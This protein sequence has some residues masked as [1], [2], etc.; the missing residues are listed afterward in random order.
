MSGDVIT[1]REAMRNA[2]TL[3]E[4]LGYT[5]GDIHD[6][7]AQAVARLERS[8]PLAAATLTVTWRQPR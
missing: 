5:G 7:L 3:L 4:A 6:N 2:L 1:I 8:F